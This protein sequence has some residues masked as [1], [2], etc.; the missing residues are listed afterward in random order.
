MAKKFVSAATSM[1]KWVSAS[2][3]KWSASNTYAGGKKGRLL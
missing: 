2:S 1:R 3:E